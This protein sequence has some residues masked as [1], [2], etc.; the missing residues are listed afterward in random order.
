MLIK[1]FQK[2][3]VIFVTGQSINVSANL[4]NSSLVLSDLEDKDDKIIFNHSERAYITKSAEHVINN[5]LPKFYD[6]VGIAKEYLFKKIIN[7]K[8]KIN[9]PLLNPFEIV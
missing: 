7:N 2:R 5:K 9:N 1:V 3:K 4:F 6:Y 8:I